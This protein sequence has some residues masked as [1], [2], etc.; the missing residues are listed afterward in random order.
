MLGML[1]K[2]YFLFIFNKVGEEKSGM[3]ELHKVDWF[4]LG[5]L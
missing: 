5:Y 1:G 2:Y 3:S 4:T